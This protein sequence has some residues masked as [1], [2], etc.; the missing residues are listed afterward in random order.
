MG[1]QFL[2]IRSLENTKNGLLFFCI[3]VG[4]PKKG[5]LRMEGLCLTKS[6]S[7]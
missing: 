3:F 5:S 7:D 6:I 4:V 1:F 2:C